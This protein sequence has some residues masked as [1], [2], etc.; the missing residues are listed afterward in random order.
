MKTKRY[1]Y[2][3]QW[4]KGREARISATDIPVIL[5]SNTYT[6]PGELME[7]KLGNL[8]SEN[9]DRKD[10]VQFGNDFE[11]AIARKIDRED[12]G[13]KV[14]Y[15]GKWDVQ[16]HAEHE[17]CSASCDFFVETCGDTGC[18]ETKTGRS[19]HWIQPPDYYVDQLRWQMF[20]T[21]L[22]F[23]YLAVLL[24]PE[25][26]ESMFRETLENGRVRMAPCSL[27][28]EYLEACRIASE[29]AQDKRDGGIP[30]I[31]RAYDES[32][33]RLFAYYRDRDWEEDA[34]K[35]AEDFYT[36]LQARKKAQ[37]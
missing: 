35:K 17:W 32:E 13:L 2:K 7:K 36:E 8:A 14:I 28:E 1:Q 16:V 34:F 10:V 18:L 12:N 22:G 5:G 33:V 15:P 21:G 27:R 26:E 24:L 6:N 30:R 20:V 25:R 31:L 3:G 4:L 11:D 9:L 23:G 37:K 19:T 29:E